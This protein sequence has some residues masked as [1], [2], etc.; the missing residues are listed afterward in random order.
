MRMN[1]YRILLGF[2]VMGQ[3]ALEYEIREARL[4]RGSLQPAPTRSSRTYVEVE[5]G[6]VAPMLQRHLGSVQSIVVMQC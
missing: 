4:I 3:L 1:L 6:I 2:H 5:L